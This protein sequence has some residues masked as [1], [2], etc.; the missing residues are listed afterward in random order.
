MHL[1][2]LH[3]WIYTA[4][5]MNIDISFDNW[6]YLFYAFWLY[7][8]MEISTYLSISKELLIKGKYAY[9]ASGIMWCLPNFFV[10]SLTCSL[11]ISEKKNVVK[12]GGR[13]SRKIMMRSWVYVKK[14]NDVMN[15][16]SGFVENIKQWFNC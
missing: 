10:I 12:A 16:L 11:E 1:L 4:H 13:Y 15:C 14:E 2:L 3:V 6:H 8:C 7:I 5:L 9:F